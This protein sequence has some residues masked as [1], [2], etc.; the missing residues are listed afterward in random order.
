MPYLTLSYTPSGTMSTIA[1]G[2]ATMHFGYMSLSLGSVNALMLSG[3][4]IEVDLS[5]ATL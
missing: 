4:A 1:E 2:W 3:N 5:M